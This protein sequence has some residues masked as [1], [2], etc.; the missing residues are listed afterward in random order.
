MYMFQPCS[1][2]NKSEHE[3]T[4]GLASLQLEVYIPCDP[5]FLLVG[6]LAGWL[7][8]RSVNRSVNFLKGAGSYNPIGA[9]VVRCRTP[10]FFMIIPS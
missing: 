9:L 3:T 10:S 5:L 1:L 7:V 2:Q 6:R 8:G 4:S